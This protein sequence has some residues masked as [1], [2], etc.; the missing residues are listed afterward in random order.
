MT[1]KITG[2]RLFDLVD[3]SLTQTDILVSE[4]TGTIIAM[5]TGLVRADRELKLYMFTCVTLD[6][7]I[8]RPLHP[9]PVRRRLVGL[10]KL[11]AC[12]TRIRRST[13]QILYR[14]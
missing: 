11:L 3:G 1:I 2:G 6:S 12:R 10:R 13:T 5:G 4:E 14:M 7:L 8:K 9:V